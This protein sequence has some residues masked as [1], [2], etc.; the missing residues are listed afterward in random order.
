MR[1][2]EDALVRMR[3]GYAEL[4]ALLTGPA[5]AEFEE[6]GVVGEWSLRDLLA[7]FAGY[8]R[9]V[10]AEILAELEHR[11]ATDEE[12]YGRPDTPSPEDDL[13]DDTS[14]AWVVAYA[15]QQPLDVV[16]DEFRGSHQRLVE[17]VDRCSDADFE[18]RARV[19]SFNGRSIASV[20][21]NQ[22]WAHYAQHLPDIQ[23]WLARRPGP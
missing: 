10:S 16:L 18:D 9:W 4:D 1:P 14:N 22:C 17:A 3:A 20:L 11:E 12:R 13:N 19:P 15:R 21:P 2:R 23:R 6:R 8:E 5:P 7:H